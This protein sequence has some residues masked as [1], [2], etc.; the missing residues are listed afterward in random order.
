MSNMEKLLGWITPSS[1]VDITNSGTYTINPLEG[2]GLS[3]SPQ[4]LAAKIRMKNSNI[5]P[6]YLEYRRGLGFDSQLK[7]TA[8]SP[9]KEGLF[10]NKIWSNQG[11][12]QTQLLDMKPT[13]SGWWQDVSLVSPDANFIFNGS[14]YESTYR[15]VNI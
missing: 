9:K 11:D 5:Y 7:A 12:L 8:T 6:F 10:V 14:D 15:R 4:K 3:A 2:V 1:I 13:S